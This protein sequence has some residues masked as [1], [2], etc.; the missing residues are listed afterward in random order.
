M[1]FIFGCKECGLDCIC[2]GFLFWQGLVPLI[3]GA[4]LSVISHTNVAPLGLDFLMPSTFYTDI[5]PL[6]LKQLSAV[7][8]QQSGTSYP[9]SVGLA[10]FHEV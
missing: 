10:G 3:N 1:L 8:H 9:L 4:P 7:S 2:F 6:G 5:A